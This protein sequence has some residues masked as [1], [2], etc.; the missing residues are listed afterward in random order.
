MSIYFQMCGSCLKYYILLLVLLPLDVFAQTGTKISLPESDESKTESRI[1]RHSLYSGAGY[2]SNMIYL[3][4]SVSQN[5]PYG[6]VNLTY[7]YRSKLFASASAVHL[8]GLNPF[9]AFYIG[10]LNFNHAFNSWFDIA[11]SASRYQIP[12]SL[13]DSLFSSFTYSD[14]TL[15]F[16]WKLLYSKLSIGGLFSEENQIYFQLR[17]SRYFQTPDFFKGKANI[18]FDPYVNLL[19]GTLIEITTSAETSVIASS[20]GR[21]W[22]RYYTS[23]SIPATISTSKEFGIME[24]DFGLPVDFNTDFMTVEAEIN[25]VLPI[26]KNPAFKSPKGFVFMLS[27]FFRI[28]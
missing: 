7:S 2:G 4:S 3:G 25:Y 18:S 8:S 1:T 21:K 15:G 9:I 14:L 16:D 13:T 24:I 12:S 22:R 17:N 19:A 6:Y 26:Y 20:P 23:H 11:T 10:A 28:F 27:A 5:Q